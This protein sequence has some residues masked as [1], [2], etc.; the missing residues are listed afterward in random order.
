MKFVPNSLTRTVAKQALQVRKQSPKLLFGGGVITVVAAGVLACRATL[1]LEE[2]VTEVEKDKAEAGL[3]LHDNSQLRS[4]GTYDEDD[5][6]HDVRVLKVRTAVKVAR[7]YAPSI[8]LGAV[9]IGMLTQAHRIQSNRIAGLSAAYAAV[10]QAFKEYR[11]RVADEFG[12]EKE[13]EI[14]YAAEVKTIEVED[15]NGPKKQKVKRVGANHRSPYA[16]MYEPSNKNWSDHPFE[17][18]QFLMGQQNWFNDMLTAH[19]YVVLNDVYQALGFER[20]KAGQMVGWV[21][22]N[23]DGDGYVDF[24]IFEGTKTDPAIREFMLGDLVTG[25]DTRQ[26]GIWL[27]F[28]VDGNVLDLMFKEKD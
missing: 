6:R 26:Y 9:G 12:E 5:Y 2:I 21:K 27:D 22:K 7:L 1:Q 10:D 24:G 20:T 25:R 19:G 3:A 17:N 15:T 28:N 13:R 11:K 8:V 4:G 18:R 16:V 14:R 23:P